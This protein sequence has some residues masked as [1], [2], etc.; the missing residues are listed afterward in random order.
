MPMTRDDGPDRYGSESEATMKRWVKKA[1]LAV[2]SLAGGAVLA[3]AVGDRLWK[4][5]TAR[6]IAQLTPAASDS[7]TGGVFRLEAL[8]GLP[9]PVRRYFQFA[10][11]PG[12]PLVRSTVRVTQTGEFRTGSGPNAP[13]K[14]FTAVQHFSA[15]P[16]GFVWDATIRMAPLVPVRVRDSYVGGVGATLAKAAGLLSVADQS[17]SPAINAGALHRYLAEAA[18]FPTALL[19][20]RGVTWEAIDD[21]TACA[22]LSDAGNIV[23]L[24]FTFGPGDE[25]VR[26]STPARFRDVNGTAVPT[27]WVCHY[28][29]YAQVAGMRVPMEGEVEWVLPEG[30]Q[31]YCRLRIDQIT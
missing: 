21:N 3:A 24:D 28:R 11:T 29:R 19:P 7:K 2:G 31:S 16:P 23:S 1:T 25:I 27:P 10:L 9:A 4:Q 17:G 6:S 5:A 12:Q 13:W 14:P 15:E 22:T 8:D 18:W 30:P 20:G 26:A